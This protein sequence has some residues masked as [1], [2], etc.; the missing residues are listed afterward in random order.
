V[1]GWA[2]AKP[3]MVDEAVKQIS[4]GVKTI[5]AGIEVEEPAAE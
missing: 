4:S 5:L 3:E 1:T 2:R